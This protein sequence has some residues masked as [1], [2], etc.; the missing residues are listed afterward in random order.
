MLTSTSSVSGA[1]VTVSGKA[2]LLIVVVTWLSAG[3]IVQICEGAQDVLPTVIV[4]F[5][6]LRIVMTTLEKVIFIVE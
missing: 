6:A 1:L 2:P 4:E 3:F 5:E